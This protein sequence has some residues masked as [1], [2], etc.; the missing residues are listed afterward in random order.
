MRLRRRRLALFPPRLP[1]PADAGPGRAAHELAFAFAEH[2][3]R[4]GGRYLARVRLPD[5]PIAGIRT[6]QWPGGD[7][8]PVWEASLPAGDASFPRGASTWRETAT[9]GERVLSSVFDVH[10][11]GRTLTWIREDCAPADTED[12]FFLHAYAADP[13]DLPAERRASGFETLNFWF[14]DRGGFYDGVC[15]AIASLPDYELRAVRTGQYDETGRLWDAG[16]APDAEAWLAR[17]EAAAASPPALRA[18]FD[19]RLE[20]RALT[21]VREACSA[22]DVADRFFVHVYAAD[23]GAR[24]NLDFWFGQRGVLHGDRCMA[25]VA[26]PDYA[27][28]RVV[29][30]Q[31]DASGALWEADLALGDAS[32]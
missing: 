28:A 4:F 17:F 6:G 23:G 22:A 10:L 25:E 19:V 1:R 31:H 11:D 21:L 24:E 29:A 8:P 14:R 5:G 2:G 27:I 13:G 7:L 30:G 32:E 3:G 20:G 15:M 26:L 12:R 9:P 16:F 18:K